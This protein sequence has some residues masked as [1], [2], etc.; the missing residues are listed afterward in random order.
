MQNVKPTHTIFVTNFDCHQ[1]L[2]DVPWIEFIAP[3]QWMC[4]SLQSS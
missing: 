3:L 2:N 1:N 4:S